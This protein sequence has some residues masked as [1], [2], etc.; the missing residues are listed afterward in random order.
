[1]PLLAIDPCPVLLSTPLL[2]SSHGVSRTLRLSG[3]NRLNLQILI[4]HLSLRVL[5][6]PVLAARLQQAC[7][8]PLTVRILPP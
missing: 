5:F 8:T 1:M 3:F 4:D 6:Y 2:F 7:Y